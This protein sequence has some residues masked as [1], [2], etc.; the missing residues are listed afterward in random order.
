MNLES[1]QLSL[2]LENKVIHFIREHGLIDENTTLVVAVSGGPDSVCLLHTLVKLRDELKINL[3]IAHL[4]HKLRGKESDEDA[5]YV[6][7]LAVQ[8]KLSCTIGERDVED[9]RVLHGGTL[10]EAAREVRYNFLTDVAKVVKAGCVAVGHTSDDNIETILLHLVR[11]TGTRGLRGLQYRTTWKSGSET[12]GIIRPILEL[13]RKETVEYCRENGLEAR[14]DSSNLSLSPLRNRIRQQLVP[15]LQSYNTQVGDALLRTARAASDELDFLDSTVSELEDSIIQKKGN[16]L[17]LDK[18]AFTSLPSALKRHLLRQSIEYILGNLKDIETRHIDEILGMLDKQAGKRI[19]L[20]GGL[21]FVIEYDRFLLTRELSELS[22]LPVIDEEYDI[23][24][25]GE[26]E[27]PGWRISA[28][29]IGR[30]EMEDS[31]DDFTAC[32][33]IACTGNKLTVRPRETAD[34][35]QPLG[36][37]QSKKVSEFMI[38]VKIPQAWRNNVPVVCSPSQVVWVAGWRIDDRT[39]VTPDTE[40]IL[41]LQFTKTSIF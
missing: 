12:V 35:F 15:L 26:T 16:I 20:P 40:K 11:G 28:S 31:N 29:V 4:N 10:E 21:V 38:D 27:M 2:Q 14:M 23:I 24:I 32:F 41:R 8:L 18:A 7:R 9:Y 13:S 33:D 39:K 34:R 22:P 6:F 30:E 1:R 19:D 17:V 3:H 36:M 37:E 5:N 25:P